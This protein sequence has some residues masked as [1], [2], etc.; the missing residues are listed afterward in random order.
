MAAPGP[1]VIEPAAGQHVVAE[2]LDAEYVYDPLVDASALPVPG[3]GESVS[4]LPVI[5]G[6]RLEQW[7]L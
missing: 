2:R 7:C 6:E 3:R 1:A 5:V 4:A